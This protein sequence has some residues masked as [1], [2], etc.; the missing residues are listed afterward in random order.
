[1]RASKPL[2]AFVALLALLASAELG[3]ADD[4]ARV[5]LDVK[6][7]EVKDLVRVLSDVAGFQVVMDP[8]VSCR[9]TLKLHAV[10]WQVALDESLKACGL[11]K[12]EDGGILRVATTGRLLEQ[13]EATR[14]LQEVQKASAP[15][16][17]VA[18]HLS[19]ARAQEMAPIVKKLLSPRG[20]VVFDA[21]TNT[22][23]VID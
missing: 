17:V 19:Y 4:E 5:S 14:R 21:R 2:R 1:M 12:E 13:T 10:R 11:G 8:G 16:R 6:D 18:F 22:L 3:S 9:L 23:L 20:D 7:L 15:L